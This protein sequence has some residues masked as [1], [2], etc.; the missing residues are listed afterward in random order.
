MSAEIE[1]FR[2]ASSTYC[3]N[4]PVNIPTTVAS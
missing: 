4:A 1:I 3:T 2:R